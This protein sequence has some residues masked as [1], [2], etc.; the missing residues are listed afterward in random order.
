[1]NYPWYVYLG[2]IVATVVGSYIMVRVCSY[3][4]SK[5]YFQA[6]KEENKND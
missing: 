3:A 2:L 1:M 5:S 6:K 4:A